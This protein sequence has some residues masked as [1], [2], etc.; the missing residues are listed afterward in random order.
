MSC[1]NRTGAFP[2]KVGLLEATPTGESHDSRGRKLL[3]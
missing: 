3:E 1:V 2:G